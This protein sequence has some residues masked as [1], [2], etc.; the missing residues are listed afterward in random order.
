MKYSLKNGVIALGFAKV[1]CVLGLLYGIFASWSFTF[2]TIVPW[3]EIS[4]EFEKIAGLCIWFFGVLELSAVFGLILGAL[5]GWL[6]G[7][8]FELPIMT[9]LRLKEMRQLAKEQRSSGNHRR[10]TTIG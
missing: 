8:V 10:S 3:L 2:E 1:G 5:V 6:I 4:K 9:Y 7:V